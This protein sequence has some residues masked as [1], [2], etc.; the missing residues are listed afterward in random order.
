MPASKS[1]A[2][3]LLAAALAAFWQQ[4]SPAPAGFAVAVS[5]GVDSFAL[6]HA[7]AGFAKLRGLKLA[8]LHVDHALFDDSADWASFCSA[9]ADTLAVPFFSCRIEVDIH[10]G[11]G[12]EGAARIARYRALAG[13]AEA[14][15]PAQISGEGLPLLMTAHQQDDQAETVL[16]RLLR[17]AGTRGLAAMPGL[18]VQH[19]DGKPRYQLARPL[20][21]VSR[22]AIL[23]YA[24]LHKLK[25]REDPLNLRMQSPRNNLRRA[26]MPQL[27]TLTP[28]LDHTLIQLAAQARA[29][30]DLI[31][32]FSAKAL[33]R[34]QTLD[35][36]VLN[37]RA[38]QQEPIN[39]HIHIM[40]RWLSELAGS[41]FADTRLPDAAA[42]RALGLALSATASGTMVLSA[43]YSLHRYRDLL[44]CARQSSDQE[45]RE[46]AECQVYWNG[47]S[48][49]LL[50]GGDRLH[51]VPP[52]DDLNALCP[53]ISLAVKF[54]SH[55][56][57][58]RPAGRGLAKSL[59]T[60][61]QENAIP[62]FRR[63][64]LPLLKLARQS[65][66]EFS[67]AEID[68]VAGVAMSQRLIDALGSFQ[69]RFEEV[70]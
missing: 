14:A 65:N 24:D 62:P 22:A 5:G 8:L 16:L 49:L 18:R 43:R 1:T 66:T 35:A 64:R 46:R 37:L 31:A 21:G 57:R 7:A 12:L 53:D 51:I 33:A 63:E 40:Q 30:R 27:R 67:D 47:R 52:N 10:A 34:C 19:V 4:L 42:P 54:K 26:I 50:P 23:S 9:F 28:A 41:L 68:A 61:L 11:F 25:W 3:D 70:S 15:L 39:L 69:L 32:S 6:A 2:S 45:I 58:V 48:P 36:S 20:L 38:F 17:G 44:Y 56:V 59:K 29:D 60:L 13:L 55:G